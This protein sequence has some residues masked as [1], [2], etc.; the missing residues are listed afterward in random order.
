MTTAPAP[1]PDPPHIDDAVSVRQG[2]H[3]LGTIVLKR[4]GEQDGVIAHLSRQVASGTSHL[5]GRLD[6]LAG[7]VQLELGGI[8]GELGEVKAAIVA[9]G[10]AIDQL[11]QREAVTGSYMIQVAGMAGEAKGAATV[12]R[13]RR[14]SDPVQRIASGV[15]VLFIKHGP[16]WLWRAL[17]LIVAGGMFVLHKLG[18]LGK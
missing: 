8:K 17:P 16:A 12:S 18:W 5:D 9:M 10:R 13:S 3:Q 4:L 2:M 14:E 1:P 6:A 7:G 11:A 15:L